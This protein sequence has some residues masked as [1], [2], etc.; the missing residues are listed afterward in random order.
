MLADR[1]RRRASSAATST[2][3]RAAVQQLSRTRTR[4]RRQAVGTGTL[5]FTDANNGSF[6]YTVNG[7]TQTKPLARYDLGTGP[8]PICTYS[9]V[10]PNFASATNYQ[11]LWWVANG[12][13]S[14][15]GINFA[16]QG[17]TI[18][19]TWYTYDGN[20]T[21]I[22]LS[23]LA[24]VRA[25]RQRLHGHALPHVGAHVQCV[26]Q[27]AS[28]RRRRWESRA[29]AFADGNHATFGYTT[30]GAGR[31]AGVEPE[32]AGHA[33]SV[34]GHGRNAL[35]LTSKEAAMDAID[36][37]GYRRD[38]APARNRRR[39]RRAPAS[40]RTPGARA[41]RPSHRSIRPSGTTL[42]RC[43]SPTRP[44]SRR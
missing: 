2:R 15:W 27:P 38:A 13:E 7:T 4:S 41:A 20:G 30:N 14:G 22:W 28:G 35:S 26:R 8:Q 36:D 12:A 42:A 11:D 39:E 6:T 31:T 29:L 19:A 44:I 3:Q 32:Q 37:A 24:T 40:G 43:G 5:T 25:D 1:T 18:F 16:H 10:T 34:R 33:L 9:A 23:V 21:P 17:N